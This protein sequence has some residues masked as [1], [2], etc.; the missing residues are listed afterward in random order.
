MCVLFRKNV[1]IPTDS[2]SQVMWSESMARSLFSHDASVLRTG[3]NTIAPVLFVQSVLLSVVSVLIGW[4]ML[5][6]LATGDIG[7]S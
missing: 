3:E 4:S 5:R 2:F 7:V 6:Y 1:I